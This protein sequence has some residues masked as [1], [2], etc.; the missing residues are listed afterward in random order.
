MIQ[1]PKV[2]NENASYFLQDCDP[3]YTARVI[4]EWC[5]I[6]SKEY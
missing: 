3:K 1:C 6:M 5:Y 4:G 2:R